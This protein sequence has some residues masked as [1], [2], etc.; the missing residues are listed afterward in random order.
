MKIR[1]CNQFKIL[2]AAHFKSIE[3]TLDSMMPDLRKGDWPN[4]SLNYDCLPTEEFV[5]LSTLSNLY[6][7]FYVNKSVV[8]DVFIPRSSLRSHIFENTTKLKQCLRENKEVQS[9]KNLFIRKFDTR[10]LPEVIKL[11]KQYHV[12]G[13]T[14]NNKKKKSKSP[15]GKKTKRSKIKT[16]S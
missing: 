1:V 7:N 13:L 8:I 6:D 11:L 4:W 15:D 14:H 16:Y 5:I 10:I 3:S 12:I 9:S 2:L